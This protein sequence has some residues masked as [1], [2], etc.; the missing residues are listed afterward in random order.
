[1]NSQPPHRPDSVGRGERPIL[2]ILVVNFNST[3]LLRG[4]LDAIANSTIADHLETIVVDNASGDFD[5]EALNAEYPWVRWMPQATN[6]TYTRG[7]NLAWERSTA[8]LVLLLNPDTRVEADALERALAHMEASPDLAALGAYLIGPDGR[9]QRYYRRLP[10]LADLPVLLFERA[11]QRTRR[12]RRF[13]MSDEDFA[14]PTNVEDIPGA[15]I[16]FRRAAAGAPPLDPGYFNFVSDL[17]LCDRLNK[18]GR[19]VV[20]PDVRCHHLRAGA[21]VGTADPR[22]RLRLYHDMTWGVR[23]YFSSRGGFVTSTVVQLLLIAYWATRVAR[24]AAGH[25]M[26][27]WS[28]FRHAIAAIAGRAPRY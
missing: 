24:L 3:P 1:M 14:Q 20:F 28:G 6:T 10:R 22:Q 7:N 17:D 5:S 26:L 2:S 16:L 11:F 13:L 25:P 19:V 8:D 21:G 12:G 27:L 15:F 18:V 4:C 23:R 9:L